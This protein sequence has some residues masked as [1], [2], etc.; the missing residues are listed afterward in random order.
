MQVTGG[1]T[2]A[3]LECPICT[4]L[5][6]DCVVST[7]GHSFCRACSTQLKGVCANCRTTGVGFIPNYFVR[8]LIAEAPAF[9]FRT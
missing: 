6:A 4:E 1:I 8:E 5:M 9:F 2:L 7:C 3:K